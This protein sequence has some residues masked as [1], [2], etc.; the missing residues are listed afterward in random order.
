MS[1]PSSPF[2]NSAELV[3]IFLGEAPAVGQ[4]V[5]HHAYAAPIDSLEKGLR[6]LES[7]LIPGNG[8]AVE[9]GF[10]AALPGESAFSLQT[11]DHGGDGGLAPAGIRGEEADQLHE[12]PG[13]F[14]PEAVHDLPLPGGE[15]NCGVGHKTLLSG[16]EKSC[17]STAIG[18]YL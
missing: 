4:G 13:R 8:G 10:P 14:L 6:L 3:N 17:W 18:L 15:R 7:G 9:P 5:D 12:G 2:Q 16:P 1:V 11:G